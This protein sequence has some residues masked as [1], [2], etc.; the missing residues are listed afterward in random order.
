[1]IGGKIG[2]QDV[3]S[4]C[5]D[6]VEVLFFG[7]WVVDENIKKWAFWHFGEFQMTL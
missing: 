3:S 4:G 5:M 7:I 2:W 1:M 6:K